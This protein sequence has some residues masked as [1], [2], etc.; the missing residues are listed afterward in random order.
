MGTTIYARATLFGALVLGPGI[1]IA[2]DTSSATH[3]LTHADA[4]KQIGQQLGL[5]LSNDRNQLYGLFPEIFPGGYE[6]REDVSY[7]NRITTLE[8]AVVT[9]VRWAGWD[10][11]RYDT[12]RAKQVAPFVSPQ[13]FPYY[14]PDPTPRSI[15]Y[16]A[17]ALSKGLLTEADL[18][19]LRKPIG[20][21]DLRD[22]TAKARELTDLPQ[23]DLAMTS[24]V[25]A[26]WRNAL[27]PTNDPRLVV[28]KPGFKDYKALKGTTSTYIDLNAPNIRIYNEGSKLSGA[29]QDY[30]PL[31]SL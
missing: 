2:R 29:K 22:L 5:P 27:L 16:V 8:E 17:V 12:A 1:G 26:P 10:T 4:A 9:L 24:S 31:G 21:E 30:F 11:V 25:T 14:K 13:G 19:K 23:G 7:P 20:S 3:T 6:G 15:P 18:P 28:L